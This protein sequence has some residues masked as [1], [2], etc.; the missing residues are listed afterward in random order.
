V[1]ALVSCVRKPF[2]LGR[3]YLSSPFQFHRTGTLVISEMSWSWSAF[4]CFDA[5]HNTLTNLTINGAPNI[6][7]APSFDR[8]WISYSVL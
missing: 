1:R 3:G 8:L 7:H 5:P 6:G 2:R 4:N